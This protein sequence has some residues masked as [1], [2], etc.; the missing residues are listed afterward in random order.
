MTPRK[1]KTDPEIIEMPS[2]KMAVVHG[3]GDPN[4]VFSDIMP[5]LYGSVYTL[6]F[7]LKKQG[8]TDF[9]VGPSRGRYPEALTVPKDQWSF[10]I[11]IPVP[12]DTKELPQKIKEVPVKL[13]TWEYGTV[14]QV[15]HIGAYADETDNIQRLLKFIEDSGY[16]VS[17]D[18]EEEYL[19][20][21]DAKV[22]KTIIRYP[23][24]KRS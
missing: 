8:I 2:Q 20:R 11:G 4:K 15:L 23:I 9:K 14:A 18:H 22:V 5:A 6:K 12:E 13:E 17:G 21:P 24:K 19:T 7:A 16:E 1:S 10:A 3:K